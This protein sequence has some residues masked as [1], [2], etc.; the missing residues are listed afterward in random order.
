MKDSEP[1]QITVSP[2]GFL[3]MISK[4]NGGALTDELNRELS[5]GVGAL[6]DHGGK[7]EITL[8]IKLS[9]TMGIDAGLTIGHDVTAKHPKE[10]RP[11]K[12]MFITSDNG[13]LDHPQEQGSLGL[14]GKTEPVKTGLEKSTGNVSHLNQA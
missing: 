13:V 3:N 6:L 9:K 4:L 1:V 12:V 14:E 10:V 7:S 8:K 2:D 11:S 5:K